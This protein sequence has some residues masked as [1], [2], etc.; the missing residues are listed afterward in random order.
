M[1]AQHPTL[2]LIPGSFNFISS[3]TGVIAAFTSLGHTIHALDLRTVGK[4]PGFPP[5]MYDDAAFINAELTALAD[6]GKEIVLVG[7]SYGG[8]PVSE[9]LKGV[10][11]EERKAVGKKGGVVRVA[12][13]TALV[14]E[15]GGDAASSLEGSPGGYIEPGEVCIF[16]PVCLLPS[17]YMCGFS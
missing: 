4:K 3:Y 14:P 17:R 6:E 8:I 10:S 1:A 11:R 12:Y 15:V 13:L 2:V 7:H 9:S 16:A 5:T